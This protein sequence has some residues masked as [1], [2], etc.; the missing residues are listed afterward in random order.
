[1]FKFVYFFIEE[2]IFLYFIGVTPLALAQGTIRVFGV[3][4]IIPARFNTSLK[5][6]P[7]MLYAVKSREQQTTQ[8][9]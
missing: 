8:E 5:H 9:Q 6:V 2:Y 1:M 7:L 3:L 4:W